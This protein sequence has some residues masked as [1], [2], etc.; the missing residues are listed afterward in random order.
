GGWGGGAGSGGAGSGG[1]AGGGGSGPGPIAGAALFFSDLT[2]GPN[3]GGQNDKGAFVTVWG[4]G[5][6]DARG[7]STVT[8]G[9][10]SADNYPVWSNGK[11]TFQLGAAAASGNVAVHVAGEN[12][13]TIDSNPLPFTVRAGNIYFVTASG[14]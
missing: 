9:G 11:I 14:S 3:Q 6:G 10:G 8:I 5:F 13:G 12:G 7:T 4:N 1:G 2:S